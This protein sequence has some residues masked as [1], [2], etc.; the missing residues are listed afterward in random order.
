MQRH[1]RI[2]PAEKSAKPW[3]SAAMLIIAAFVFL[4]GLAGQTTD[5]NVMIAPVATS[6]PIPLNAE[7]DESIAERE[8][9][10]SASSWYALQLGAFENEQ[11]ANEMA[12]QFVRRGAAGY[13]WRDGR[14]RVLA[15]VYPD[16]EDAQHVR[17][18]LETQH[19][20]DTY[21]YQIDLPAVRLRLRGMQGQ[22]DILEAAFIHGNDLVLQL[23]NLCVLMDRQEITM[24]ELLAQLHELGTLMETV[25]LRLKQRFLPPRPETVEG[26]I[27]CLDDC[28]VFCSQVT[29]HD[30]YVALGTKLKCQTL[31]SLNGLKRV[32][33]TLSHT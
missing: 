30:S 21:L 23:Q 17:Q 24:D 8:I 26:L 9:T 25:T 29:A 19:A 11:S 1:T 16:K 2:Y 3:L 15:A 7:F 27:D 14:Y 13:V 4:S 22:L 28:L 6:T 33:D 31:V 18:Q 12:Q 10:L 32:Y 5:S 20:I